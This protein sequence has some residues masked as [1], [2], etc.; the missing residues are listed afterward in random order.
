M[1]AL[2]GVPMNTIM[3]VLLCLLGVCLASIAYVALRNRIIFLIGLRNI[4]RRVAQ[5]A[6][7]IIGL[8]LSTLIIA[9]AFATGDIVDYSISNKA[10][11]ILGHVD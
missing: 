8:M 5:T 7:I 4:P 10:Y 9:A 2:F 1:H 3:I 6:L 11:E